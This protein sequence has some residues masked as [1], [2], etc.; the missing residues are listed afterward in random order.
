MYP[1][2]LF[3]IGQQY[4]AQIL[5]APALFLAAVPALSAPVFEPAASFGA[6]VTPH[7]V[8]IGDVN[9]DGKPDLLVVDARGGTG[10]T[11]SVLLGYGDGS[12]KPKRDYA[13][14]PDSRPK[15]LKL[16]DIN[17]DGA[18]DFVTANQKGSNFTVRLG[19][20]DGTFR[21]PASYPTVAKAHEADVGEIN[22]DG[23]VDLVV[24]GW[25][26][27]E[28]ALRLG[29]GKGGFGNE[30]RFPAGANP[31]SVIIGDFNGDRY[32]DIA[33]GNHGAANVSVLLN[34]RVGGFRAQVLYATASGNHSIRAAD[35]DADGDL[36]IVGAN[37]NANAVSVL[38]GNGNGT[39]KPYVRY[40][41]GIT[42]KS[43]ALA[44][45]D[46]DLKTD[47]ITANITRNYPTVTNPGRD[48]VSVLPGNGNGTFKPRIDYRVGQGP[49]SVDA[50]DL[51][52]DGAI[53]IV[54]ANWWDDDASVLVN[55]GS[56]PSACP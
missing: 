48:T 47:I 18:L 31:H 14:A 55:G 13:V 2:F 37:D 8:R 9:R 16:A 23:K 12:F 50:G 15:S 28:V 22:N 27:A 49:F 39:F 38:L 17:R 46:G 34:N 21:P 45:V 6:G 11:V 32:N 51:N 10:S 25:G 19:N 5:I 42:P 20:G 41:T 7:A 52:C 30:R 3:N 1:T 54:T 40:T 33:V 29:D 53:D 26:V 44:D 43:V 24:V 35:I 56:G 36:D 4:Y